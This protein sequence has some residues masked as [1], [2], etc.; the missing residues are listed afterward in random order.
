MNVE[1]T[2]SKGTWN[3]LHVVDLATDAAICILLV[4]YAPVAEFSYHLMSLTGFFAEFGH[5]LFFFISLFGI[6]FICVDLYL[7]R[8]SGLLFHVPKRFQRLSIYFI[9]LIVLLLFY[10]FLAIIFTFFT[11]TTMP[12]I[13][14]L[15]VAAEGIALGAVFGLDLKSMEPDE[16]RNTP[17]KIIKRDESLSTILPYVTTTLAIVFPSEYYLITLDSPAYHI[18]G[19]L[20][21]C[22]V[23]AY[24]GR[25]LENAVSP[26]LA[27]QKASPVG[28]TLAI[29]CLAVLSV[30][31][32]GLLQSFLVRT[33]TQ[34]DYRITEI[35]AMFLFGFIPLRVFRIL[36]SSGKLNAIIG[37]VTLTLYLLRESRVI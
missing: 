19:T 28:G 25:K 31:S 6:A 13:S 3:R 5:L 26:I 14:A 29:S 7:H 34:T 20:F 27:A 17:R 2:S 8:K 21:A 12:T 15:L 18:L 22:V 24:L 37:I 1:Q 4:F 9:A 33:T 10:S 35:G 32:L 16:S 23:A 11:N 30:L 36:F